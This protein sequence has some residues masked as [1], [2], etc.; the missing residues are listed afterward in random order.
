MRYCS[1]CL[2]PDTRPGL[3]LN[4]DGVC[5]AC[6]NTS[7]L[8]S[9]HHVDRFSDF[10]NH[11]DKLLAKSPRR[12]Y[13]CLIGVSGGKD[14]LRQALWVR[15]KLGLTPLLVS[16]SFPPEQVSN[17]GLVNLSN[18]VNNGFDLIV[19]GP[20]PTTWKSLM[21]ESLFRF[22]NW[23]RSTELALFSS[24][25]QIAIDYRI[26]I[27][28][29]GENPSLQ[30]GDLATAGNSGFDGNNLRYSNTLSS[31][32]DWMLRSGFR[33]TDILPYV[34]PS[35]E[36]FQFFDINILYLGWPLTDWS[37]LNNASLS[38]LHGLSIRH[39]PPE[40]TG[41]LYGVSNLDED[42]HNLNQMLKYYKYGFGKT[43]EYV[44]E[45]IRS[46]YITR[47][48]GITLVQAYDGKC[49]ESTIRSFCDYIGLSS[50]DW[51]RF[52]HSV[53]NRDLFSFS[54]HSTL[55]V[56]RFTIGTDL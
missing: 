42:W 19:S 35:V 16:L 11:L 7:Q 2:Q 12:L 31:G 22:G 9:S 10:S 17:L 20:A 39:E 46:G 54:T 4:D 28:F 30:V 25:P 43:T 38:C 23:A 47:S 5:P 18:L 36:S 48:E 44:C 15:D 14:S 21:K 51:A 24:V 53:V 33:I 49:S 37:L 29:W 56:P 34:Y 45:A 27:I 55:P 13:D 50:N 40:N 8:L 41:D 26:P 52:F 32:H 1:S 3:R 6:I